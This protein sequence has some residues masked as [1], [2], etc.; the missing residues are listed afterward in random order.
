M[1]RMKKLSIASAKNNEHADIQF[2]QNDSAG[3][4][5]THTGILIGSSSNPK[6]AMDKFYSTIDQHKPLTV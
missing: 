4:I 3:S 2:Y 5:I 1:K 6:M